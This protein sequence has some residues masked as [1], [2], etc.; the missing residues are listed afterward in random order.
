[1]KTLLHWGS[2]QFPRPQIHHIQVIK[3]LMEDESSIDYLVSHSVDFSLVT[4]VTQV[5]VDP[6]SFTSL[7]VS[8]MPSWLT[9]HRTRDAQGGQTSLPWAGQ[10]RCP[11]R[12]SGRFPQWYFSSRV[13]W[14]VWQM[15]LCCNRWTLQWTKV[16]KRTFI[17]LTAGKTVL[18]IFGLTVVCWLICLW[19]LEFL[20]SNRPNE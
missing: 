2:V 15:P 10:C 4:A 8:F 9:S 6:F 14:T 12:W 13:R 20:I 7:A 3:V 19:S 18:L 1:M 16:S 5:V 17:L 11:P